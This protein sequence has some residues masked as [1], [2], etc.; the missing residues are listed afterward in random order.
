MH[1]YK[2][3]LFSVLGDSISTLEGYTSPDHAAYYDTEHKLLSGV[4]TPAYTWWG[5]AVKALGGTLLVNNSFLGSTVCRRRGCE[6]PS[7]GCC[8]ERTSSLHTGGVLPD[9]ILVFMGIN[10]WGCGIQPEAKSEADTRDPYVFST[11]YGMMLSKLKE[12][13]P[14][15]DI[16]CLTLPV[17]LYKKGEAFPFR[18]GGIHIE[19]YC[20]VI[21][22][23]ALEHGCRIADL[24]AFAEPYSTVDGFHPDAKGM[25]T[26]AQAVIAE[27]QK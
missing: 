27:L 17:S 18:Y 20:G 19:E 13:H 14:L 12:N 11:A 25:E 15:A 22:R 2:N 16:V 21:R 9:V 4:F 10:D 1:V 6:V 7:C 24:Y 8:D 26:L 3:K 23:V 5:Q